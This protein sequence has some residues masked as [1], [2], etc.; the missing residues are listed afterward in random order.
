MRVFSTFSEPEGTIVKGLLKAE[1]IPVVIKGE[2]EGPYRAGSMDLWVPDEL[3]AQA[4]LI[5]EDAR[6]SGSAE[7]PG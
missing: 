2:A 6:A 5:L 1:G 7:E 4:R 3:E